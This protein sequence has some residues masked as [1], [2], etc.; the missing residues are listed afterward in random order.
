MEPMYGKYR[1]Q[2]VD[3]NDPLGQGRLRVQATR[4]SSVARARVPANG[5]AS[6]PG[7]PRCPT[8]ATTVW[9]EFEGGDPRPPPLD[10]LRLVGHQ[11]R[12]LDRRERR[13]DGPGPPTKVEVTA[14][15]GPTSRLP[16][17][18]VDGVVRGATLI[19]T[20]GVVSPSYTPGAGNI[21]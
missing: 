10:R 20:E 5:R 3:R 11:R 7:T 9:I 4:P 6:H 21:W 1:A 16:M 13:G 12:V 8:W 15:P 19:A 14:S 2:V 18:D 17:L